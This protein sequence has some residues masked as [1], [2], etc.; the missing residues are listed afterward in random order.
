MPHGK[1]FAHICL[2]LD[3]APQPNIPHLLFTMARGGL[4]RAL[5]RA[6]Q[7]RAATASTASTAAG[8]LG[9]GSVKLFDIS[10]V[11]GAARLLAGASWSCHSAQHTGRRAL[12]GPRC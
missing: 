1:G 3:H 4:Q 2:L 6:A 12:C 10:G 9:L 11:D 7:A 8:A 5:L